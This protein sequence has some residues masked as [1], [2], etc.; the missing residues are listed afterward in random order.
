V[1]ECIHNFYA[2]LRFNASTPLCGRADLQLVDL[3]L[4]AANI[5]LR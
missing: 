2:A 4:L 3:Q 1:D 5:R